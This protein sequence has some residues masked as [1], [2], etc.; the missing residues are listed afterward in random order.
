MARTTAIKVR[1][2][3]GDDYHVEKM[4]NLSPFINAASAL[5]DRVVTCATRRGRSLDAD[6]QELV[7]TWLAAHFYKYAWDRQLASK[8]TAGASGS[9]SGQTAMGF[10]G[11]TYGQT[12]QGLDWSGCLRSMANRAGAF[13]LGKRK[14][15]QV[16]YVE[17]D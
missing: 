8:S 5:I 1:D 15:E 3:L 11:T 6:E 12:A 16:D 17:R 14:S 9:Y 10:D 7:E 4:P 13:W 2:I